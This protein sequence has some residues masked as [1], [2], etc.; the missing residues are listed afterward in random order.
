MDHALHYGECLANGAVET[1]HAR[2]DA[3]AIPWSPHPVF[4]GVWLKHLV[5]GAETGGRASCH[6]VRVEPGCSLASHVHEQQL[7]LHEVVVG[8]GQALVQ[9]KAMAYAPG[10][11]AVIPQGVRHE[12]LASAD[13]LWL[14]ATFAPALK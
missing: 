5:C 4:A 10:V 3:E 8:S 11:V 13:G 12:V 7:E 6:L 1:L 9:G 2:V 14:R